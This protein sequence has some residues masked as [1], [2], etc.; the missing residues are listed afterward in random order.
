MNV[1]MDSKTREY[2]RQAQQAESRI[3][4]EADLAPLPE[5][6]RRYMRY[7][8]VI[9]KPSIRCSKVKQKGFLRLDP[10]RK[11]IPIEAV[12]YSTLVGDLTRKWYARALAGPFPLLTGFDSYDKGAGHMLMKLLSMFPVVDV[13]GPEV[14]LSALIIFVNDM[15]MWPTAFLSD[16]IQW[17]HL[18]GSSAR[19]YVNL[20]GKHF[21]AEFCFNEKGELVD[22]ITGDRYRAVGTTFIQDKW[23]TPLRNYRESNGFRIPSKGEAIWH[24]PEG[25][26][27]YIRAEIGEVQYDTFD[28]D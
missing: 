7:A 25:E 13:R 16:Y 10:A 6:V 27:P 9:G 1:R 14:D 2:I 20:Y 5:P 22:F 17:E 12:Q 19:A 23:S 11:W 26:F 28:F 3:I 18:N 4:T 8:Q 21:S 15:V 24:L